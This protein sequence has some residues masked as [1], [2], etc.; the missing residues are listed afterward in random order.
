[1]RIFAIKNR[2]SEPSTFGRL[3][4]LSEIGAIS[5]EDAEFFGAGFETLMMF[6]IRKNMKQGKSP[7][8]ILNP[9]V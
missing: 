6:R 2:I 1:M 4:Q 3:R 8:I 5:A 7:I 9:T